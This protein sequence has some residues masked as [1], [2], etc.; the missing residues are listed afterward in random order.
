MFVKLSIS[1]HVA[2]VCFILLL[3]LLLGFLGPQVRYVEVP[4]LGVEY[5]PLLPAYTT[6]KATQDLSL[7]YGL[8]H[9][10]RQQRI[11]NPQSE[12]RDRTCIF[13]DTSWVRFQ[14]SHNENSHI[15]TVVWKYVHC[16]KIS[17][18]KYLFYYS[19][20][21]GFLYIGNSATMIILEHV[22]WY[23]HFYQLYISDG[24]IS[25]SKDTASLNMIYSALV[26]NC[27][28][29]FQTIPNSNI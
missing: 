24:Y 25:W 2:V 14:L 15:F 12:A 1:L 10:S 11:L 17:K 4:R 22:F 7:I 13:M 16:M 26:G 9:S 6:A 3:L 23:T 8:H 5:E 19:W 28:T 20:T 27:Q 18:F 29:I 21:S